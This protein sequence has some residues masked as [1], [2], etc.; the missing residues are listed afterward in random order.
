VK[1]LEEDITLVVG[2]RDALNVQVG[3]A[4][5]RIRTLEDEVVMLTGTVRERDD[6]L[7]G[8]GWEVEA[9]RA[10]LPDR[11]K[12]LRASEKTCGELRDEVMGWQTH[13]EGKHLVMFWPWHRGPWL[14]LTQ[15]LRFRVGEAATSGPGDGHLVL[16]PLRGQGR[17]NSVAPG[18][19]RLGM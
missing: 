14:M 10:A 9:L 19:Y 17:A 7:S 15:Y 12:A 6:A 3:M 4:S 1:E 18:R 16:E 5:T 2:Q 8:A 11:D 13:S